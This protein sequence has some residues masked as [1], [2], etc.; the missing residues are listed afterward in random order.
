MPIRTRINSI[1]A[2][3]SEYTCKP[4][5]A[6]TGS[7]N[8]IYSYINIVFQSQKG[9]YLV[10]DAFHITD[11]KTQEQNLSSFSNSLIK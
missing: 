8:T 6:I 1:L 7:H 5:K 9:H 3:A 2:A 11:N 10:T 4:T